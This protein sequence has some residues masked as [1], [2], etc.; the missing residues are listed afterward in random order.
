M[1]LLVVLPHARA[2][3]DLLDREDLCD[4][5][6]IVVDELEEDLARSARSKSVLSTGYTMDLKGD[7]KAKKRIAYKNSEVRLI[8]ALERV[9]GTPLDKYRTNY[10]NKDLPKFI[11]RV[12]T[13][14]KEEEADMFQVEHA[15]G[16]SPTELLMNVRE[17]LLNQF[18]HMTDDHNELKVACGQLVERFETEIQEWFANYQ[19]ERK[20]KEYLCVLHFRNEENIPC[21]YS[22]VEISK[23]FLRIDT[24]LADHED[25]EENQNENDEFSG[26]DDE[27][28]ASSRPASRLDRFSAGPV[29]DDDDEEEDDNHPVSGSAQTHPQQSPPEPSLAEIRERQQAS[30][31]Y[32]ATIRSLRAAFDSMSSIKDDSPALNSILQEYQGLNHV[33]VDHL[34]LPNELATQP[35]A[36]SSIKDYTAKLSALIQQLATC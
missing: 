20:L 8:E 7:M 9:C 34:V 15:Q 21:Y 1:V 25:E 13:I 19:D 2:N 24:A 18:G 33:L 35:N 22:D 5:C 30:D 3:I 26:N 6:E 16:D 32:T 17:Q 36:V 27:Q 29:G 31:K 4:V 23:E 11:R 12:G 28:H 14:N 10:W